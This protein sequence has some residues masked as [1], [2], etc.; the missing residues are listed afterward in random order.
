MEANTSTKN[1]IKKKIITYSKKVLIVVA[2]L[3]VINLAQWACIQ[4]LNTYCSKPG[5]WGM[6]ENILSLGSPVCH[7]VNNIQYNLSTYYVQLWISSGVGI[8]GLLTL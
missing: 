3:F 7:F 6:I 2:T 5:V 1:N 4:F 8:I